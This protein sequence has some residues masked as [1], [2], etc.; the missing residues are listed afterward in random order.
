M[1]MDIWEVEIGHIVFKNKFGKVLLGSIFSTSTQLDNM[2]LD[3]TSHLT[4]VVKAH[5]QNNKS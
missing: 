3:C 1:T 5:N 2:D 4:W